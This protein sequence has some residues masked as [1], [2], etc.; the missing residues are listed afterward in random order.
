MKE[1]DRRRRAPLMPPSR[2]APRA[3]CAP[4]Q[5]GRVKKTGRP[6]DARFVETA[7]WRL[8]SAQRGNSELPIRYASTER[9]HWRPSRIA[10]TTSDWPRRMSP[11]A[12]TLSTDV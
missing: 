5:S 3:R 7:L 10:Q 8:P 1:M 9:A 11:A 12:N 6:R 2:T 4:R